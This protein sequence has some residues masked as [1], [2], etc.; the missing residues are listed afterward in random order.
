MV[1]V[2]GLRLGFASDVCWASEEI[3]VVERSW[4]ITVSP[5]ICSQVVSAAA[6]RRSW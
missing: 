2:V 4:F 3:A 5:S 1:S 6:M